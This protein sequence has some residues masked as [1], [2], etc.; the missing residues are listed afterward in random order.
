M[1]DGVGFLPSHIL[2]HHGCF[3]P[4]G[5]DPSHQDAYLQKLFSEYQ[6]VSK[7][8]QMEDYTYQAP[9]FLYH[10]EEMD[11]KIDRLFLGF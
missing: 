2:L 10:S 6:S 5:Y 9:I 11:E 8:S 7:G 4:C 1:W 3:Q